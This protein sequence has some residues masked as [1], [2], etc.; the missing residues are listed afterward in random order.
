[1]AYFTIMTGLR[2]CYMPDAS[3]I[4]R[5]DTRRDLKAAIESEA[6]GIRDCYFGVSRRAVA[7]H[8][9]ECWKRRADPR[10]TMDLALP[11]GEESGQHAG[12]PFAIFVSRATREEF[13]A[14]A[15]I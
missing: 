8:A 13:L 5:A 7:A 1:M 12:K 6:S 3:Y 10:W 14:Q 9:A 2:G 11:Y 15:E 4:F